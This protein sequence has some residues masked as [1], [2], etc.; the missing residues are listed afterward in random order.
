MTATETELPAD[1]GTAAAPADSN[2]TKVP[3]EKPVFGL[4]QVGDTLPTVTRA[5]SNLVG[6]TTREQRFKDDLEKIKAAP[7]V[8]FQLADYGAG[9]TAKRTATFLTEA[10]QPMYTKTHA[11]GHQEQ[12]GG[13]LLDLVS[14]G[15]G[16]YEFKGQ[17]SDENPK[18]SK[19]Y[20]R[21][22][23]A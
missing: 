19:L 6:G 16:S 23:T 15:Q 2:G 18:R 8:W 10:V 9:T 14:D 12:V 5:T 11:D 7:G 1:G 21:Y 4:V 22:V 13:E 20:A 3:K 17:R